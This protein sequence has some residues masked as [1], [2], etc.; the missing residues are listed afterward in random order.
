MGS[1]A[2]RF[3]A[4]AIVPLLALG[5]ACGS[6]DDK[7][8]DDKP[9][10]APGTSAGNSAQPPAGK[11]DATPS[12]KPSA[13]LLT[14]DQLKAALVTTADVPGYQVQLDNEGETAA[15]EKSD[16]PECQ[17]LLQFISPDTAHAPAVTVA[18]TARKVGANDNV[19]SLISL[20]QFDGDK[21]KQFFTEA[22]EA[23]P[24]CASFVA[25]DDAGDKVD[26]T[27]KEG[28]KPAFGDDSIVIQFTWDGSFQ[29]INLV[30]SGS[31][32]IHAGAYT[33]G[34]GTLSAHVPMP[35]AVLRAQFDKLA[36]AQ[37]S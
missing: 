27:A 32:I 6:D 18:T 3:A 16:K 17:P 19:V 24:K 10:S 20:G 9:N 30:R 7:K 23:L 8:G 34:A 11:T 12:G 28:A 13:K 31:V 2:K 37:K 14:L 26:Y 4:F 33:V 29:T 25:T 22:K 15:P 21:A 5:T 36:N 35:E 1:A